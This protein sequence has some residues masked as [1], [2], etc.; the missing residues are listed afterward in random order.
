MATKKQRRRREKDRRHE[1][2]YVYIDEEGNEVEVEQ[3]P[4]SP[5]EK[6]RRAAVSSNSRRP[7][8][9]VRPVQ[10]PSWRFMR[11][12]VLIFYFILLAAF[13]ILY[14]G[15]IWK[16]AGIAALYTAL[17][18]PL[19]WMMQRM[20]YRSYLRRTGQLPPPSEPRSK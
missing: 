1:Y 3:P 16:S 5:K 15:P 9:G 6:Q 8:A 4:P 10:P 17:M 19:M 2:E 18:L 11:K 7:A 13:S 12:Q 20:M 14:R